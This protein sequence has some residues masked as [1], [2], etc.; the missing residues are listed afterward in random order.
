MKL[1]KRSSFCLLGIVLLTLTTATILEKVYGTDFVNTYIYGSVPFIILW[2]VTALCGLLYLLKRKLQKHPATFLLH[3][4][5]LVILAGA[6]TTRI[7]GE[8]GTVH[9]RKGEA[10]RSFT[11]KDNELKTFPFELSLNEFQIIYYTGTRAPMDF[12]SKISVTGDDNNLTTTG[13]VAMNRIFSH[14]NYRF[15]QAGYDED[16]QGTRL[17]VSYDPY[18]IAITY[19]GYMLLLLS[20]LLFFFAKNSHLR[21]LLRNPLLKRRS[22]LLGLFLLLT[23]TSLQAGQKMPQTLPKEIAGQFGD[24]YVLYN[25]RICPLQTLARDFTVKLYGNSS[26]RGLTSE[27]VFT[28]WMFYYSDWKDEPMIKLK[29]HPVRKILGTEGSYAT[30][31]DFTNSLNEFKLDEINN[32][33]QAGESVSDKQGIGEAN[34]KYNLIAMLFSGKMLK[35]YP[36]RTDSNK[37]LM[38]YAQADLLPENMDNSEWVFIRKSLSY[39]HEMVVK[40]EY[41]GLTS[42]I[43]KIKKYQEKRAGYELPSTNKFEAEKLYNSLDYTRALAICCIFTGLIAFVLYCRNEVRGRTPRRR[44]TVVLNTLLV[45]AF[46]YLTAAI[47]LRGYVSNHLP[48]SNGFETMQF[49]A[50][51]T[52]VLTFF[53]QRRLSMALP[54]GFLL[55][56]LAL[57]V[58]RMGEANPQITQLM[59]VLASPLLCMHVVIIMAAYSLL[60]F[61]LLNGVTAFILYYSCKDCRLQM[62]RLQLISQIMLYPAVFLLATGIFIGAVWANVSWGRYWGWDPKEVWALITMLVYALA[63]HPVSLPRFRDPVFF[64]LFT[65]AAFLCVAITYF[66]VNFL[67]G[68]MHSYAG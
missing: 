27:Q 17:S 41:G 56:G 25:D 5:F 21:K 55:C 7:Y 30:L 57:M 15:Y 61:I 24:L 37:P 10:I 68:G 40:K 44:V 58:S 1:L 48:L 60:A 67:L 22:T 53:L 26:Y 23:V 9:L 3:L 12:I 4:T 34:E 59:P 35:L 16:G 6:L 11:N 20:I 46:I 62:E 43:G 18:G 28:G 2:I 50:W 47:S 49:M 32:R 45:I 54:F 63:L 64:H 52:L 36:Y 42:L 33:I 19:T 51:F 13:E 14:R 8:Q 29:S 66:G 38:W 31:A 65:I 39:I